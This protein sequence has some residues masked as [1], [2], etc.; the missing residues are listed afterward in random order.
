MMMMMTTTIEPRSVMV[1]S[2]V[3]VYQTSL[4]F[5]CHHSDRG[6]R[7]YV[8][9]DHH[10]NAWNSKG[11]LLIQGPFVRPSTTR[12]PRHRRPHP[13]EINLFSENTAPPPCAH[14]PHGPPR[15]R[16]EPFHPDHRQ[17]RTRL[18][19]VRPLCV[20]V[21]IP[22]RGKFRHQKFFIDKQ[23]CTYMFVHECLSSCVE[24]EVSCMSSS[25]LD[26]HA[27]CPSLTTTTF[28]SEVCPHLTFSFVPYN[29]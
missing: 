3:C 17:D 24:S 28:R 23:I 26:T 14:I 8:P 21:W 4:T 7:Q 27:P 12:T 5:V 25:L 19:V 6:I 22:K 11:T 15:R 1:S 18:S 29:L 10:R 9:R 2:R 20:S 13:G 16:R